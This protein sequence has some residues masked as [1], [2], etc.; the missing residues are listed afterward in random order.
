MFSGINR[1]NL[2][3]KKQTTKNS[4]ER[5]SPVL[6]VVD[7][8]TRASIAVAGCLAETRGE[9]SPFQLCSFADELWNEINSRR[10][11]LLCELHL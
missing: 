11:D 8:C 1:P 9:L 6:V 5:N 3:R 10:R 7:V 2:S 4:T